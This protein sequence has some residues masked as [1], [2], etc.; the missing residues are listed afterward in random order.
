MTIN[1]HELEIAR[2]ARRFR[3]ICNEHI[4]ELEDQMPKANNPL[5]RDDLEKQIDAMHELADQANSRAKAMIE[6][7]YANQ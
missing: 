5:E 6:D 1:K 4:M 7:Y 2:V 3:E